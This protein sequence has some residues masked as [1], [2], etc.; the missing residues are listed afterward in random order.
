ML[1]EAIDKEFN[2]DLSFPID[3]FPNQIQDLIQDAKNT[4]GFN[5]IYPAIFCTSEPSLVGVQKY[6]WIIRMI[7]SGGMASPTHCTTTTQPDR[8][9]CCR[10]KA[11]ILP[12]LKKFCKC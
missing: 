3:I 8:Q 6:L 5:S 4:I 2:S 7:E 9:K 1:S 11:Q 12:D 10:D